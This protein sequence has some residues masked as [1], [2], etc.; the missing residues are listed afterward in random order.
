M[1]VPDEKRG[2]DDGRDGEQRGQHRARQASQVRRPYR[3][4]YR[5]IFRNSG[6]DSSISR[7]ILRFMLETSPARRVTDP[8][9][10]PA[11][12]TFHPIAPW[13]FAISIT[14]RASALTRSGWRCDCA[15]VL[16]TIAW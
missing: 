15:S 9:A 6:S 11:P 4:R 13:R 7:I 3:L 12:F 5:G 10:P 14:F 16:T 2:G 8:P 1:E